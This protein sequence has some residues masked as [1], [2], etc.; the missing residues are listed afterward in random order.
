MYGKTYR[1]EGD[2]GLG[3]RARLAA[4]VSFGGLLMRLQGEDGNLHDG[5]EVDR[6]VYLLTKKVAS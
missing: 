5:F 4:Y 1:I 2:D 6:S 3:E